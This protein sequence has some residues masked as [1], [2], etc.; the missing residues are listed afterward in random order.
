MLPTFIGIGPGRTGTSMLYE[1]LLEHPE[2][3]LA[4]GTKETS[5]FTFEYNKGIAWYRNFYRHAT[6]AKAIGEI[7]TSYFYEE[8]V[9]KRMWETL[10]NVRL[11]TC[12]RNPFERLYSVYIYRKRS[13]QIPHDMPLEKALSNY[14]DLIDDNC[15]YTHLTRYYSYFPKDQICILLYDD[16]VAT[17]ELFIRKLLSFLG[18]TTDFTSTVINQRIN[19]SSTPRLKL[20]GS[21]AA[22]T[23]SSLRKMGFL[24]LLDVLKR[25]PVVRQSVLKPT[26][27]DTHHPSMF[28]QETTIQRLK[29][30]WE[31]QV[32]GVEGLV[33]RSLRHWVNHK[34]PSI[35]E[36]NV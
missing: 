34:G 24:H 8:K 21:L 28:L 20:L 1:L 11:F 25:S 31:P 10:P 17:P 14:P 12:L 26:A 23:A 32:V 18:V 3:A 16:L 30:I 22:Y 15:Y 19:A 29:K 9:P 6:N 13:K 7:S 2:I 27:L 36:G 4:H 35:K 33:G 5:F